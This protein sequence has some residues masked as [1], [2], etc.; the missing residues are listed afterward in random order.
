MFR[1]E[2]SHVIKKAKAKARK[3]ALLSTDRDSS[4]PD[5]E[6][7]TSVT[8]EPR[9]KPLSLVTPSS[10]AKTPAAGPTLTWAKDENSLLPSPD[11]GSWPTTPLIALLYSLN[12]TYQ[13]RGTAFFFSR[14]VTVDENGGHQ[15]FDF[16]YDVWKPA[17]LA[18]ERQVDGVLA[19]MTAVGLIGLGH[20]I[21]SDEVL[22]AA[23][24][25]YGTALRLTNQALKNPVEAARDTTMLSVL[26]LSLFEMM[27]D[28][29]PKTMK[30]WQEHVNGAVA[31]AGMRGAEQFKRPGGAKMFLMLCYKVMISCIQRQM[32]MP[33]TLVNLGNQL[34]KGLDDCD[35][36][37][38]IAT[39]VCRVLQTRYDIKCGNISEPQ[40]ILEQLSS[41]EDDFE[42]LLDSFPTAWQHRTFKV[43]KN[44]PAIFRNMCHTYPTLWHATTW[45]SIRSCRMLILESILNEFQKH[46]SSTQ[47]T[48]MSEPYT[49]AFQKARHKLERVCEDILAS[50]PQHVGLLSP[51]GGGYENLN[52]AT[53]PIPN[54]TVRQS[55]S[56]PTS[57][58]SRSSSSGGEGNTPRECKMI[59]TGP[60][61][62]NP[63]L[64][65]DS[66]EE[67]K[68]FMLL[69]SATNSIVWPLYLVGMASICSEDMKA[70]VVERLRALYAETGQRQ[71]EVIAN[72]VETHELE[73]TERQ[74]AIGPL[75]LRDGL[76]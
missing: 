19:S 34:G 70:Y 54:V 6:S 65:K 48:P 31:L 20:M 37:W 43:S 7:R 21:R 50:V 2:S 72:M 27:T 30:A 57:P 16:V 17:S 63:T 15:R 73:S 22:E 69:A 51:N 38:Q 18:P 67:A 13:E 75:P 61:L 29:T 28:T 35:P 11:S 49:R 24:K 25:S 39:P 62:V 74:D 76:T 9:G 42:N 60:T 71:A 3:K 53:T 1:D 68:R 47:P 56:P 58:S 45:N 59:P 46:S 52:P 4:S 8:P 64:S 14:Y 32:P 36:A 41:I 66:E 40:A 5:T 23:R 10:H 33:E 12:P 44:H 26:I 55:P